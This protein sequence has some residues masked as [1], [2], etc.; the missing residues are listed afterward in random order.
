[1]PQRAQATP[2]C[3]ARD[4]SGA[5]VSSPTRSSATVVINHTRNTERKQ[6]AGC[7]ACSTADD[8]GVAAR[9]TRTHP[10]PL[11][12]HESLL[13]RKRVVAETMFLTSALTPG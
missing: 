2:D 9:T 11:L 6:C 4:N 13:S 8:A 3:T 1:M 12:T 5:T 10:C 7:G